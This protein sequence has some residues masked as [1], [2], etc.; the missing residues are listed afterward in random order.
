MFFMSS[1]YLS[2]FEVA[3]MDSMFMFKAMI[4][5]CRG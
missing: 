4:V 1:C 5:D 2:W 3:C